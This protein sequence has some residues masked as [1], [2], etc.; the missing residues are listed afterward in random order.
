MAALLAYLGVRSSSTV[1]LQA[2]LNGA[3]RTLMD[4][5]QT[6]RAAH[7]V[8]I[9]ELESE[10]RRQRGEINQHIQINQSLTHQLERVTRGRESDASGI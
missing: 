3:F 6:E 9:S 4:E 10:V 5:W 1:R 2:H 7:I 8:R